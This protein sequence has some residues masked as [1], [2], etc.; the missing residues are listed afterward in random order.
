MIVTQAVL[1]L[2]RERRVSHSFLGA[3]RWRVGDRLW[4]RQDAELE[5]YCEIQAGHVLPARMG[6]FSYTGSQLLPSTR[7]G[8]YGSIGGGVDFIQ[9]EHPVDWASTSPVFYSPQGHEGLSDYL[10]RDAKVARYQ[11][12]EYAAKISAPVVIGNDVFIGQGVTFSGGV[13]IGDGA[14]V[15]ARSL[16]T[17][18]VPPY[19]VVGGVPARVIRMRFPEELVRR[20]LAAA[21]WRFGPDQLQPLDVRDPEGFVSR[22]EDR[23][24]GDA[25]LQP[26]AL[27]P[28]TMPEL[29]AAA[30]PSP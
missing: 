9:S 13:Q 6:A 14:A 26:L 3:P 17:R 19:A 18:D 23:L 24:A 12:H 22:L 10:S 1:D 16:V 8:R 2:L 28:L 21:W 5:P 7:V 30:Q 27:E 25:P 11:T 15:G 4:V 29:E 20:L